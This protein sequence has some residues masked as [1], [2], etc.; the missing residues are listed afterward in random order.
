MARRN[1]GVAATVAALATVLAVEAWGLRSGAIGSVVVIAVIA[2]A[3][4][5]LAF[6]LDLAVAGVAAA[7]GACF[8]LTWN[9]WFIGP[10]RPG[11]VLI[12]VALLCFVLA[13]PN[14]A[15]RTPP[16][17]IKQLVFAILLVVVAQI[18]FPPDPL[19]M[20]QRIVLTAVGAPRPAPPGSLAFLNIT[21]AVKFII[22]VAATP[23]A[24]A[25]A[26]RVDR[27]AMRW[28]VLAFA[29]GA[30]LSGWVAILDRAGARLSRILTGLPDTG[31]R[32]LGFSDH[33]NYLAAGIVLALPFAFWLIFNQKAFDRVVGLVALAGLLLGA[34]A[35]GSRG[36][37]VTT[38]AV[39]ALC[40]VLHPRTRVYT[41]NA[42]V[43]GLIAVGGIIAFVPGLGA[44]ILRATRLSA[45]AST[46]GSD[47]VRAV[48]GA[49]GV[50]DFLHSPIAGLGLQISDQASQVYLQELA[51]GGLI[52]FVAMSIYMLC[53]LITS[54]ALMR[55]SSLGAA[56]L[57]AFVGTLALNIFEADLTDRFY[58]VPGAL[59]VAMI[60]SRRLEQAA[61][62]SADASVLAPA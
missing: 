23:M 59:L 1:R 52:L 53:G 57:A 60:E 58:Y 9:G 46:S 45:D 37:A 6:S 62:A 14:G 29:S 8:T 7:C 30:G 48:V 42:V 44:G 47:S 33:P 55:R 31:A 38:V 19:Y 4:S 16:W 3:L 43:A 40:V 28:L 61:R 21:V 20:S 49:Q 26:V 25:G 11:D 35:S 27:R 22:A 32:Q 41:V 56:L 24:F 34:Y 39:L 13:H 2:I 36:G 18:Y 17:W 51:S 10:V 5:A 12:I 50:R 54:A 15:F